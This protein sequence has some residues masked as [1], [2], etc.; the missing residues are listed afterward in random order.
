[1]IKP[2]KLDDKKKNLNKP[3]VLMMTEDM[4]SKL[5]ELKTFKGVDVPNWIR[6]MIEEGIK[7]MDTTANL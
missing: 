2:P 6:L 1:M 4:H 7:Y 3:Y 5:A